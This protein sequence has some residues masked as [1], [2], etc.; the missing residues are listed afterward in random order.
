MP[1]NPAEPAHGSFIEHVLPLAVERQ[2]GIVGMKVYL[3]GLAAHIPGHKSMEPYLRFAV[4]QS[5]STVVIG[6]DDLRQME[7]NVRFATDFIPM[8]VEEQ[9]ELIL[10]VAPLA[11]Q[12]MYYKP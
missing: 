5:V 10:H 12:L 6:C 8:V 3:R 4:S 1:V 9:Q 7:E 2:M 11:R